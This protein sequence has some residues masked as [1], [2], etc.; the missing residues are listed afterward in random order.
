MEREVAR[1]VEREERRRRMR[2]KEREEEA[3]DAAARE[4]EAKAEDERRREEGRRRQE[5]DRMRQEEDQRRHEEAWRRHEEEMRQQE[6]ARRRQEDARR[7][8]EEE[9][10]RRQQEAQRQC[11]ADS[12]RQAQKQQEQEEAQRQYEAETQRQRERTASL[13]SQA[14]SASSHDAGKRTSTRAPA[15]H[16]APSSVPSNPSNVSGPTTSYPPADPPLL[17]GYAPLA[18]HHA[19]HQHSSSLN[20]LAPAYPPTLS[21]RPSRSFENVRS[22]R[23]SHTGPPLSPS[24]RHNERAHG[25]GRGGGHHRSASSGASVRS[26]GLPTPPSSASSAIGQPGTSIPGSA[27]A[28]PPH[29]VG[30]TGHAGVQQQDIGPPSKTAVDKPLPTPGALS[31]PAASAGPGQVPPAPTTKPRRKYSLLAAF[32]LKSK[33]KEVEK[34]CASTFVRAH[35]AVLCRAPLLPHR[36]VPLESLLAVGVLF[37]PGVCS[38]RSR[39]GTVE[40][41]FA[42]TAAP[43][44]SPRRPCCPSCCPSLSCVTASM[45]VLMLETR[46]PLSHNLLTPWW[47]ATEIRHVSDVHEFARRGVWVV[48]R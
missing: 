45:T 40:C 21:L 46:C 15:T 33:G 6:D 37:A 8:Q 13:Q 5:E 19:H 22:R 17:P 30:A 47:V 10:A 38:A 41:V 14:A 43:A 4:E 28:Q 12:R 9:D 26:H 39:N 11:E 23:P 7:R 36:M 24:A 27:Q 1:A 48:Y 29:Q 3:R 25:Y 35:F 44:L 16:R 31:V 34:V 32:G 2:E 18:A 42:C 20:T